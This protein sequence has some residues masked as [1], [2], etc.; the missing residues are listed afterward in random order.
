MSTPPICACAQV[1]APVE[2][3][4]TLFGDLNRRKGLIQNSDS[5]A[6][7]VVMQAQVRARGANPSIHGQIRA[8]LRA[9]GES[10]CR[11]CLHVPRHGFV[12]CTASVKPQ[13]F[14]CFLTGSASPQDLSCR[15]PVI[16]Q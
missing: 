3:Q 8:T 1:R 14:V 10:G 15:I 13:N 7:E 2:F 12:S 6:D 9:L 4:G 5:E 16:V 11:S